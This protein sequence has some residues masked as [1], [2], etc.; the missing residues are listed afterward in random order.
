MSADRT[1]R[2]RITWADGEYEFAIETLGHFR[3]LEEKCDAGAPEIL[4]RLTL[5]KWR[6][7]D[8]RETLRIGLIGG[9]MKPADAAILVKRYVDERPKAESV[10]AAQAV[11]LA[12]IVGAAEPADEE[13]DHAGKAQATRTTAPEG[14]TSSP[15][16][17]PAHSLDGLQSKSMN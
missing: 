10:Q 2:V 6:I 14:S 7:N 13:D 16:T 17:E 9:G 15:F 12:A 3:E 4:Q 1:P 8:L 5:Q 11:L